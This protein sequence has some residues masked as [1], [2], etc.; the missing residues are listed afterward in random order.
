MWVQ[1]LVLEDPWG[2]K[3][4]PTPVFLPGNPMDRGARQ[5]TVHGV[6]KESDM[7]KVTQNMPLLSL[8]SKAHK[9]RSTI[10]LAENKLCGFQVC[11]GLPYVCRR[12][13]VM[14]FKCQN[15]S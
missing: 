15:I 10:Y 12:F 5:A 11:Q 13:A 3:Q 14:T 1:S 8:K 9:F 4:Q 6:A 7:T 2:R